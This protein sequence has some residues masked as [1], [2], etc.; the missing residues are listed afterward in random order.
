AS[1]HPGLKRSQNEDAFEANAEL[2]LWLV[3]DGVGGHAFG[4]VASALVAATVTEA[5]ARGE[6]LVGALHGAHQAVLE[7]IGRRDESLGMGA[8]VVAFTLTGKHYHLA[9]VGDS[10]A[11]LW[12][13]EHLELLSHDHTH[14]ADLVDRGLI[15]Q[16]EA[17]RHPE[18]HVL[19]QSVGVF[20]NMQLAP[21]ERRG[22]LALGEQ[23]LLCSDGLNDELSDQAIAAQLRGNNSCQ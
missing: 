10:R 23:I 9:W 5:H 2:G 1:T 15:S 6:E 4:D 3:A 18:R 21:G 11:Y 20:A 17:A 19:T 16:A 13:G 12:N 14:V 7:E 8:T 22:T